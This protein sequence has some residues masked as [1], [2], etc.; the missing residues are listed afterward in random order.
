M[1]APK[2]NRRI[3]GQRF[4]V[5]LVFTILIPAANYVYACTDSWV[6]VANG[7]WDTDI[8]WSVNGGA[9][10]AGPP[11]GDGCIEVN[12]TVTSTATFDLEADGN[13]TVNAGGTLSISGDLNNSG[14]IDNFGMCVIGN[15]LYNL[16]SSSLTN[17]SI[18]A[19][20]VSRDLRL[21]DCAAVLTN[22]GNIKIGNDLV[23]GGTVQGTGGRYFAGGEAFNNACCAAFDGV[24]CVQ[25]QD[26]S[27]DPSCGTIGAGVTES[28]DCSGF[29]LPVELVAFTATQEGH[30]IQLNWQTASETDND[31]FTLEKATDGQHFYPL[32]EINGA[33]TSLSTIDYNYIDEV[34][35]AINYYR[36]KQ[37]DLDGNTSYSETISL[38]LDLPVEQFSVYP[39]PSTTNDVIHLTANSPA[40]KGQE[41]NIS[42]YDLAG[43]QLH[44][45]TEA[46]DSEH[47]S[48][49]LALNNNIPAGMYLI[50]GTSS[51]QVLFKQKLLL[52][53]QRSA[54]S[55]GF[56]PA[57]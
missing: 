21:D 37:T 42:I 38:V 53:R 4:V 11:A 49:A 7:D 27:I 34:P 26:A 5:N 41:I 57:N 18:G 22:D 33:G 29:V 19:M 47:F 16:S 48:A 55:L 1:K 12:H 3:I 52:N 17:H 35:E 2:I 51:S 50:V 56:A 54:L 6:T 15:I 40:T 14:T 8:I 46:Q 25:D 44:M 43:R 28:S 13:L 45:Q 32:T 23:N 9:P 36:L 20:S 30:D 10:V 31:Y 24:I 39:N